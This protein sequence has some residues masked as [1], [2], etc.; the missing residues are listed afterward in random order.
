MGIVLVAWA[1][2]MT[3]ASGAIAPGQVT[4]EGN[5]KAV[6]HRDGGPVRAVL[7]REGQHVE[8]GQPLVEL[9]QGDVQAEVS[10][11][12]S[13]RWAMLAKLAR[14]RAEA[15][16]APDIAWP[17]RLTANRGDAQVRSAIDQE[18]ALFEARRAAYRG[19][20]NL[21]RQQIE[22]RRRQV[23]GFVAR[24]ASVEAQLQSVE[25][26]LI[27]LAPL[28]E[29]GLIPRPRALALE[30]SAAALRG[31]IETLQSSLAAEQNGIAQAETQ[32]QQLEKDRS[33]AVARDVADTEIRLAEIE[34]RLRSATERLERAVIVAP[35]AGSVYGLAVFSP[36]A[37]LV[38]GQTVLEIVPASEPLVLSVEIATK[39]VE[40][41]RPGQDVTVHLLAYSQRYQSIIKGRLEKVSGDRFD[42][43]FTQRSYFKGIIRVE[44]S[45]LKKAGVELLPGMPVNVV[46]ETGERTILAYL[47]D[48]V[49]RIKDFAFRER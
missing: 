43:K 17:D 47:L 24:R 30:R 3:V 34:P 28:L 29:K 22:G 1:S 14:L 6:Q 39:D 23:E 31:D 2:T 33:E 36:G 32:I 35:E 21:L 42:D 40:R 19:N 8:R 4:F 38:P 5:R 44:A 16:D 10:V 37:V 48:P 26:E 46:I 13:A 27:S 41:V 11:L 12:T 20:I 25:D 45:E 15:Q 49:F 9:N 7:V 18:T